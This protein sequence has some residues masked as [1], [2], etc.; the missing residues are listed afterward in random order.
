MEGFENGNTVEKEK[1]KMAL[2]Y[3]RN[4]SNFNYRVFI[5]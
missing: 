1:E 3:W 5:H 4:F 2:D